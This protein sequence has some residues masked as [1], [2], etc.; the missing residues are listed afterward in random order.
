MKRTKKLYVIIA[1]FMII[2]IF[3]CG[4]NGDSGD[5]AGTTERAQAAAAGET[6][7]EQRVT[8]DLDETDYGER[9]FTFLTGGTE[10]W[11]QLD[12]I[13]V[14]EEIGEILNDVTFSRTRAVEERFNVTIQDIQI[15]P[16]EIGGKVRIAVQSGD[17]TYDAAYLWSNFFL[18]LGANGILYDLNHLP[19]LDFSKPYWDKDGREQL[20][21]VNRLYMMTGDANMSYND[22]T[23][24]MMFNKKLIQDYGLDDPYELVKDG[25]WT[26]DKMIELGKACV[27]DLNGD[28][29]FSVEDQFGMVT[30]S[31]HIKGLFFASGEKLFAKNSDDIPEFNGGNERALNVLNRVYEVMNEH[32][33]TLNTR[34]PKHAAAISGIYIEGVNDGQQVMFEANQALFCGEILECVRRYRQMEMPFGL[35]PCPKL[36]ENQKEYYSYITYPL[37]GVCVPANAAAQDGEFIGT[38]L[39]AMQSMS[40]YTLIPAYFDSALYGKFMRDEESR[41]MLHIILG[42]RSYPWSELRDSGGMLAALR[43]AIVAGKSDFSSIIEERES[44]AKTD[45]EKLVENIEAQE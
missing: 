3:A 1:L 37:A 19:K 6:T 17:R 41:D 13:C 23:W 31:E 35:L 28:G 7:E 32:N 15:V 4:E 27:K 11:C 42:N 45:I 44:R 10:F 30:H 2:P 8:D 12:R 43:D 26:I 25:K 9:I 39:E 34:D 22:N 14:E 20:S 29:I 18:D 36:D 5:G 24:V 16:W 40:R 33:F 38:I 21:I